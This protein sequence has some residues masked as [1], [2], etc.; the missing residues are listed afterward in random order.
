MVGTRR[1]E[2]TIYLLRHGNI[3]QTNCERRYIGQIDL[4]L[5][6]EGVR[7]AHLLQSEF[8]GKE[9]SAAFCSDLV[10]S[11][12]TAR[13]ICRGLTKNLIIRPDLREISMGEWEGKTFSDISQNY[14]EQYAERGK[15]IGGYRIPGAESFSECK[16]RVVEAFHEITK[17]VEGNILIVAHAG[18]NRL[19]LGH[20]LGMP[21]ENIFRI[22]QNYGCINVLTGKESQFQVELLNGRCIL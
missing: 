22:T 7:Q 2:K 16:E 5:S 8:R 10:R 19:L 21:I 4:P 9:I 20:I 1:R 3:L 13:I 12:D 14:P 11:I 18:V 6:A 15:N 17:T